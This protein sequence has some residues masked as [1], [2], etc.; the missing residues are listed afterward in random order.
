MSEPVSWLLIEE[1]WDVIDSA[2]DDVGKVEQVMGD[3]DIF[4]GLVISTSLL[5]RPRWV[6]AEQ[7]GE[8]QAGRVQ[9][10]ISST[11]AD[12]L[13]EYEPPPAP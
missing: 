2:G 11:A 9:L 8:I 12:Q 6:P 3:R 13:E 5:G 10:T 7:I 4:S 1:G